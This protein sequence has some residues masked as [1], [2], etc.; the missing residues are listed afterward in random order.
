MKIAWGHSLEPCLPTKT[1]VFP[2]ASTIY[3][4]ADITFFEL[5]QI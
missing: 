4:K 1:E 3:A 2:V 5:A